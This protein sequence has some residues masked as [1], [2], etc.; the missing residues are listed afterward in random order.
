MSDT[1]KVTMLDTVEDTNNWP[2]EHDD[3]K[4]SLNARTD[5]LAKGETY[6]LPAKQARNLIAKGFAKRPK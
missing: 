3:G 6:E 1:Q 5:K 2:Q 4:V